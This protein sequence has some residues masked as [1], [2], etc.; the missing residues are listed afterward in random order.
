L[1]VWLSNS[2]LLEIL[3]ISNPLNP[4]FENSGAGGTS[5]SGDMAVYGQ[6]AYFSGNDPSIKAA[7]IWPT[8]DITSVG[9]VHPHWFAGSSLYTNDGYLYKY[10]LGSGISIFDLY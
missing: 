9:T 6:Y 1:Y 2:D 8:D 7:R 10:T 5:S 3:D 4:V